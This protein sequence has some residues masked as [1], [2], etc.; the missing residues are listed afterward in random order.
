M[1]ENEFVIESKVAKYGSE[2]VTVTVQPGGLVVGSVY[3]LFLP[4]IH[5]SLLTKLEEKEGELA[6]ILKLDCLF[7]LSYY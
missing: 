3:A 1:I 2:L 4:L 7:P 5:V 6:R